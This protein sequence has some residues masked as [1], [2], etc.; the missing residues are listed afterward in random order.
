VPESV[1]P[2]YPWLADTR[3]DVAGVTAHLKGMK[4][5]GVP[6]TDVDITATASEVE[7]KTEMDAIVAFM[8]VLG[9]MTRLDDEVVYRE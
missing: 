3:L 1:M 9:T 7:G 2:G 4:K 6:Y 5:I 8:Q